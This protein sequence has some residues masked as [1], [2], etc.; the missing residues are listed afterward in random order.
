MNGFNDVRGLLREG[1][2]QRGQLLALG[3]EKVLPTTRS[4]ACGRWALY[5]H[6][7]VSRRILLALTDEEL[8]DIGLDRQ[9]ACAEAAKPFWRG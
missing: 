8:R 7:W 3:G 1:S 9:Q 6:R 4:P 2:S 5:R